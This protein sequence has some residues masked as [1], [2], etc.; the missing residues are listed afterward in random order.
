MITN[1]KKFTLG[2]I[3]LWGMHSLYDT[4]ASLL[5]FTFSSYEEVLVSCEKSLS[6]CLSNLNAL[7]PLESEKTVFTKVSVCLSACPAFQWWRLDFLSPKCDYK[8]IY[9]FESQYSFI[10]C[11]VSTNAWQKDDRLRL[12]D[13]GGKET[14]T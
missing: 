6:E 4:R 1:K 13:S 7:R 3:G 9:K 12:S 8:K 14:F 10:T 5:I 2:S 11:V